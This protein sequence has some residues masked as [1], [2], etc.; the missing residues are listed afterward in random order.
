MKPN[1]KLK[2]MPFALASLLC[3]S[4]VGATAEHGSQAKDEVEAELAPI[5][6]PLAGT[7]MTPMP[8]RSA[9][10]EMAQTPA[11]AAEKQ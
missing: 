1:I 10:A 4:S 9:G 2:S 8:A 6:K 3:V 7:P 5:K 11:G